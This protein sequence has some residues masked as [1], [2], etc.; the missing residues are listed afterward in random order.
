MQFVCDD[1]N[2]SEQPVCLRNDCQPNQ[3]H[4]DLLSIGFSSWKRHQTVQYT[5]F[6][7][8]RFSTDQITSGLNNATWI[9]RLHSLS[10]LKCTD[11][12][13]SSLH[14]Y[15]IRLFAFMSIGRRKRISPSLVL[16]ERILLVR[17]TEE[18][19]AKIVRS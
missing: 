6:T 15:S 1:R 3:W 13:T 8:S 7:N 2:S 4:L 9:D 14:I 19:E 18:F 10:Y 16:S 17:S 5:K 12:V 11:G